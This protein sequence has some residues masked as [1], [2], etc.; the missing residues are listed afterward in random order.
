MTFFGGTHNNFYAFIFMFG[1]ALLCRLAN[2]F[3]GYK[4][5]MIGYPVV[6]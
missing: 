6:L 2:G 1:K 4:P 5:F 3:H